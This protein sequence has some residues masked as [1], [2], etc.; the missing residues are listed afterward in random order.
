LILIKI[1]MQ[2]SKCKIDVPVRHAWQADMT[3]I[4]DSLVILYKLSRSDT[5]IL[6]FD[7]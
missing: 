7:F 3:G 1:K 2:I 6:T 5:K 4:L